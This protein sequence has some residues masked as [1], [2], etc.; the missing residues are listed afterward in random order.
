MRTL[1]EALELARAVKHCPALQ[2]RGIMTHH[3]RL[4]VFQPIVDAVRKNVSQVL[5]SST[6]QCDCSSVLL[7][8]I[9]RLTS[10]C[11]ACESC[12]S[13]C[14]NN[15]MHACQAQHVGAFSIKPLGQVLVL[16]CSK[17]VAPCCTVIK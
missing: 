2:L 11:V 5:S 12:N 17:H 10:C 8:S 1:Q 16:C 9:A 3:G 7:V 6:K 15:Y 13:V 14:Q 4:E